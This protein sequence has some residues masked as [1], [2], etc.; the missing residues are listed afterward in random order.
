MIQEQYEDIS[1]LYN[2]KKMKT[3]QEQFEDISQ[4]YYVNN[5]KH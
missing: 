2:V 1:H 4:L 5:W 3:I